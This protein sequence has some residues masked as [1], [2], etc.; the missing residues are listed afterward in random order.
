MELEPRVH[1][2][3]ACK[4]EN[5]LVDTGV[6][7]SVLISYCR[8]ISTETCTILVAT[9]KK[10]TKDSL[11]HFFIAGM[12]KYFPTSFQWSLSVPLSFWGEIFP[13]FEILQLM[14]S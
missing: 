13:A 1:L 6:T 7:Y 2:D 8:A 14:Q 4:S 11:E 9:G 3:V 12:D 10:I 5:F